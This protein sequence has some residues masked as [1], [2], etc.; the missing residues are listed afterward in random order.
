MVV[1]EDREGEGLTFAAEVLQT[2]IFLLLSIFKAGRKHKLWIVQ[3]RDDILVS[4]GTK[5]FYFLFN[6]KISD[7][8][9]AEWRQVITPI[10]TCP[11][12]T[13]GQQFTH[14]SRHSREWQ[15]CKTID[16]D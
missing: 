12:L 3:I 15:S 16:F 14:F 10:P 11:M 8:F 4:R 13:T 2:V 6:I 7:E 1:F 9:E 5:D